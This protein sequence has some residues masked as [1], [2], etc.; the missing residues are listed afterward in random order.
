MESKTTNIFPKM[1]K[2]FGA[3][4]TTFLLANLISFCYQLFQKGWGSNFAF[5]WGSFYLN[6][7][8]TGPVLGSSNATFLLFVSF[9]YFLYRFV[10]K[11]R[12]NP[13][14]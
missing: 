4:I 2:A 5:K 9:C 12:A 3:A 14:A 1:L 6:G 10:E 8:T 7:E 13:N 11:Q